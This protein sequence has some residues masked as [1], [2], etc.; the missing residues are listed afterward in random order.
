M[1]NPI[2]PEN[3][4]EDSAQVISS[5]NS[6]ALNGLTALVTGAAR[7]IGRAIALE[8][9]RGGAQVCISDRDEAALHE[10][11]SE[12]REYG[13][14]T[15]LL[16][17]DVSKRDDCI[18][19]VGLITARCGKVDILVNAAGRYSAKSFLDSQVE[20]FQSLLD[21]NLYGAIHLMQAVL[22]GMHSRQFGRIVN[23]ASTTG[24]WGLVNQ[25]AYSVSKHAVIGLTRCVALEF[26][27]SGITVNAICPGPVRTEML[28]GLWKSQAQLNACSVDSIK[29][30]MVNRIPIGRLIEP[31]EIAALVAYLVSP[32]SSGVTAQAFNLDGGMLQL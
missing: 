28:E 14:A 31:D 21:V 3:L 27:K 22:P 16:A 4:P 24:K 8:L 17:L 18:G 15:E 32:R 19:A 29:A 13:I 2:H 6:N 11:A 7:G 23:I 9:G 5:K 30:A 10:T 26:A 20:D 12:L 25:S 1:N